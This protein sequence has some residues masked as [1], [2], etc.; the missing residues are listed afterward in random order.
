MYI[1]TN[2]CVLIIT[3][4]YYKYMIRLTR[5][6]TK[7]QFPIGAA[8]LCNFMKLMQSHRRT[9]DF[10]ISLLRIVAWRCLLVLLLCLWYLFWIQMSNCRSVLWIRI[11]HVA[12]HQ[13]LRQISQ[14]ESSLL[15]DGSVRLLQSEKRVRVENIFF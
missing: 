3:T 9:A 1:C 5:C 15:Q 7:L 6:L 14:R 8:R 11:W 10:L 4:K 13:A 12:L 2:W